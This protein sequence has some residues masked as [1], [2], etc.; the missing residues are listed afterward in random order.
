MNGLLGF[1]LLVPISHPLSFHSTAEL[2]LY[3]LQDIGKI[4]KD[5]ISHVKEL[6]RLDA[7]INQEL[8]QL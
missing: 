4:T 7:E 5:D 6:E 2:I 3:M 8:C 1:N